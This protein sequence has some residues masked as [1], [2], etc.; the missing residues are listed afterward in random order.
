MDTFAFLPTQSPVRLFGKSAGPANALDPL[1]LAAIMGFRVAGTT[2]YG[3]ERIQSDAR[4]VAPPRSI[5]HM[6]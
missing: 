5:G 2:D 4:D 1:I 3:C 6:V